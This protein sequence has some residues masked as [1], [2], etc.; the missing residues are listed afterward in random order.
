MHTTIRI[1]ALDAA[2]VLRGDG[3]LEAFLPHDAGKPRPSA[4]SM[5]I[6]M[7]AYGDPAI[8]NLIQQ[9]MD[10]AGYQ[11]PDPAPGSTKAGGGRAGVH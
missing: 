7:C 4:V 6:L 8:M 9:A 2:L 11:Y 5:S 10:S 3:K 1:T